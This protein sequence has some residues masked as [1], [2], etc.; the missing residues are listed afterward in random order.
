MDHLGV[1]L[2]I[3]NERHAIEES[4]NDI[5]IEIVR[6]LIFYTVWDRKGRPVDVH[7]NFGKVSYLGDCCID[8]YFHCSKEE[9]INIVQTYLE[10]LTK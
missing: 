3:E 7:P 2:A 6:N 5:S 10:N 9:R 4:F 8:Q 1:L